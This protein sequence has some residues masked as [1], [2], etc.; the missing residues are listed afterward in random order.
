[1]GKRE[2]VKVC[3]CTQCRAVSNKSK[4]RSLKKKIKRLMNKK[5]RRSKEGEV[6]NFYWA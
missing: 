4:N 2:S 3:T 1:M 5:R 6:Y